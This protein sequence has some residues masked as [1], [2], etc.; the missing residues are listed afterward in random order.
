MEIKAE[1]VAFHGWGLDATLWEPWEK[2]LPGHIVLRMADRGYFYEPK[3]AGFELKDSTKILFL[4]SYGLHWC[5]AHLIKKAEL[6][7][8]FSSFVQY[9]ADEKK[10]L[11]EY[12]VKKRT[13]G[14]KADPAG[15]YTTFMELCGAPENSNF[16]Q[17]NMNIELM[18]K[19]LGHL[20]RNRFSCS[21]EKDKKVILFE[22]ERDMILT[23]SRKN[24]MEEVFGS[25]LHYH[26]FEEAGH[27]LPEANCSQCYSILKNLLPIFRAS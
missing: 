23:G 3:N 2:I 9:F 22:A 15:W 27:L 12:T 18:S 10:R 7:V 8:V 11:M 21:L 6:M 19:D 24:E 13:H 25:L 4:H 17:N 1:I 5:P 14:F 16:N 26:C 20:H